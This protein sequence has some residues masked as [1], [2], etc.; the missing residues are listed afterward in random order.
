MKTVIYY[1][2]STDEQSLSIEAQRDRC[3]RFALDR[4]LEIIG[5]YQDDGISGTTGV[6]GRPGLR[7][8]IKAAR[9]AQI[10]LVADDSRL[11]R[12]VRLS[13][14]I[15]RAVSACGATIY[16]ADGIGGDESATGR[17]I[18]QVM[19]ARSELEVNTIKERTRAALAVKRKNGKRTSY[20]ATWGSRIKYDEP[21]K[22]AAGEQYPDQRE[23]EALEIIKSMRREKATVIQ[24]ALTA[25]GYF[26]RKG[27]PI[28]LTNIKRIVDRL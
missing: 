14:Q 7:D 20:F 23:Q 4:G 8:A 2:M 25:R 24:R 27:N 15:H 13:E 28:H 17:F 5:E 3:R 9:K 6:G 26:N 18:R 19:S 12:S 11:C 22:S 21:G 1:R 10:L 16:S